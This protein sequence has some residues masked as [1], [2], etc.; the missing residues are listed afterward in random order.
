VRATK[1]NAT[2]T[3]L[4]DMFLQANPAKSRTAEDMLEQREKYRPGDNVLPKLRLR[5]AAGDEEDQRVLNEV[6]A[7]SLREA[8]ISSGSNTLQ[9]PVDNRRRDGRGS[10]SRDSSRSTGRTRHEPSQPSSRR[11]GQRSSRD[12]SREPSPRAPSRH[13]EH[14]SSLRSLM[15]ASE[16]DP[17]QMQE[18]ILRQIAEEGLLDGID[19]ENMDA[20]Q[21]EELSEQIAHEYQLRREQRLRE[22]RRQRDNP[23]TPPRSSA[24]I[25][26]EES[27]VRRVERPAVPEITP[28]SAP[29][30]SNPHLISSANQAQPRQRRS[31][32]QSSTRSAS[33]VDAAVGPAGPARTLSDVF[34]NSG[35]GDAARSASQRSRRLSHE[36]SSTDPDRL[37]T[38]VHRPH[39]QT[40][41]SAPDS[42]HQLE[43]V[44]TTRSHS[45]QRS[46]S[47]PRPQRS[48]RIGATTSAATFPLDQRSAPTNS[49]SSSLPA[50]TQPSPAS[51]LAISNAVTSDTRPTSSSNRH[52][53]LFTEPSI[54]CDRC[55][56][57]HI[58]YDI[59]FN[60]QICNKG[61]YNLC[62]SC[63]RQGKGCLHWYGFGRLAWQR[64]HKQ[65]PPEGYPINHQTPHILSGQRYQRPKRPIVPSPTANQPNRLVSEE[66]PSHRLENGVFC[67]ICSAFANACYWKCDVCNDGDWGF[68]NNCVNQGRHCTHP[69]IPL[70]SK[71]TP[72]PRDSPQLGSDHLNPS[73]SQQPNQQLSPPI[74]PRSASVVIN[75]PHFLL[76]TQ[77]F[78]PLTFS[79]I[80][81]ICT[82]P[83]PPTHSRYHCLKCNE[84]DYD[85][86]SQ[87]YGNLVSTGRIS[88]DHGDRGWRTCLKGHRMCIIGFEDRDG[89]QRRI[90]VAEMKGG[91]SLSEEQNDA[92]K[93]PT[94]DGPVPP[95]WSWKDADGTMR[96]ATVRNPNF[97]YQPVVPGTTPPTRFPPDGGVGLRV[98]AAWAYYP[99][100][101]VADELGF[102]KG[103]ELREVEDINGDW[104][105][106]VYAGKKG[107][108]PGNYG[109]VIGAGGTR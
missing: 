15:S 66:D 80:C 70:K 61:K 33:R 39:A 82:Y 21:E 72:P 59:H 73:P 97:F 10:R 67:D 35:N 87:C 1:P 98:Y 79:T 17:Q 45:R 18:E 102:P 9:E 106:G 6:T 7:L 48:P 30:V 96:K 101:G 41:G 38:L 68:C 88:A 103:A 46:D 94:G 14:Q 12:P 92:P 49:S 84:G 2:V 60:C 34:G 78:Q 107:L 109:V 58:E 20:T 75:P 83:I 22:E 29:P 11:S 43:A 19:L 95:N 108:F 85:I 57:A 74:T 47:N 26:R 24:Q 52:P 99:D 44:G 37:R 91:W 16:L 63:Y 69:L 90:V 100:D 86:C 42:P 65:E 13:I 81:D 32:S 62:Q 105:C 77:P 76:A 56:K 50:A 23:T 53:A 27:G 51:G 28:S 3:T 55:S 40:T 93:S 104:F 31:G 54:S 36:R 64:Y 4:L 8:G 71:S 25:S 5:R 89:G